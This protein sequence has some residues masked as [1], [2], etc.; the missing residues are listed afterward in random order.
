MRSWFAQ[1]DALIGCKAY[2]A[3]SVQRYRDNRKVVRR[4]CS[5]FRVPDRTSIVPLLHDYAAAGG[6]PLAIGGHKVCNLFPRGLCSIGT[7][8]GSA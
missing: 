7:L 2:T 1:I 3:A 6:W 8:T 4:G 5:R